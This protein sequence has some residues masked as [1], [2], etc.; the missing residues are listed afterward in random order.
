M[1]SFLALKLGWGKVRGAEHLARDVPAHETHSLPACSPLRIALVWSPKAK[2]SLQGFNGYPSPLLPSPAA[3]SLSPPRMVISTLGYPEG[4]PEN[5]LVVLAP[6]KDVN[7]YL[8]KVSRNNQRYP[9]TTVH[10]K[11]ASSTSPLLLGHQAELTMV[12]VIIF[13]IATQT[14]E[15]WGQR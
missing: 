3:I 15:I 1:N 5:I 2:L 9:K 8:R 11:K 10:F 12:F 7:R 6:Q 14:R 13:L 4:S